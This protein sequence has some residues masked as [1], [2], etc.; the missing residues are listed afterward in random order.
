MLGLLEIEKLRI[1]RRLHEVGIAHQVLCASLQ[2]LTSWRSGGT[3][4]P[5]EN[6]MSEDAS[7]IQSR[8]VLVISPQMLLDLVSV[9]NGLPEPSEP[10][11]SASI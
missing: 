8:L 1:Q 11:G 5:P 7:R 2:L 6:S 9:D 10:P 3:A 4:A